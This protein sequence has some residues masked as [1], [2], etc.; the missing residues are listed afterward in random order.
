M[1]NDINVLHDDVRSAS[2]FQGTR[3][4]GDLDGRAAQRMDL[5]MEIVLGF[6]LARCHRESI[7]D[8]ELPLLG[9]VRELPGFVPF[10]AQ[11]AITSSWLGRLQVS[12]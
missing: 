4:L 7:F 12:Q 3:Y 2:A 11:A 5:L 8:E 6:R 10:L 1:A 9:E